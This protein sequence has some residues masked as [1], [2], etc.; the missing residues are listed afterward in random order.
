MLKIQAIRTGTVA[1]TTV[2]R[3][4][5]RTFIATDDGG[6]RSRRFPDRRSR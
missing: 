5:G 1:V 2:W 6:S 4:T 3:E